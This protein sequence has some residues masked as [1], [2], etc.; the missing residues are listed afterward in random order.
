[1]DKVKPPTIKPTTKATPTSKKASTPKV[2]E[3]K[4]Q[5]TISQT[6]K[7]PA[8]STTR[9]SKPQKSSPT[10]WEYTPNIGNDALV[11]LEATSAD[12]TGLFVDADPQAT[13]DWE[14]AD[15][16]LDDAA[17]CSQL[18]T[19]RVLQQKLAEPMDLLAPKPLEQPL[20]NTL[21]T[22]HQFL[23]ENPNFF[24][25][26][27]GDSGYLCFPGLIRSEVFALLDA[28]TV[29]KQLSLQQ[30]AAYGPEEINKSLLVLAQQAEWV[31]ENTKAAQFV[32]SALK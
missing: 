3:K 30:T 32:E 5:A 13:P 28:I 11:R 9:T 17:V 22:L 10:P 29:Q 14:V 16:L 7:R 1:M 24:L 26:R 2:P 23:L 20:A 25:D 19:R 27:F 4:P 6:Q 15:Q 18:F 31:T 12:E 8:A 21:D